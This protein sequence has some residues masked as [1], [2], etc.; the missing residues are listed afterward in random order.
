M[1]DE[2][3]SYQ[4]T[5]RRHSSTAGQEPEPEEQPSPAVAATEVPAR[6]DSEGVPPADFITFVLSLAAQVGMLLDGAEG[7]R[8]DLKGAQWLISIIE[9]LRDKTEGRRTAAETEALE[10]ILYE[11]RLA[12]VERAKVGGA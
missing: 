12:Y 9:M 7:G 1:S 11:L 8:P 3:K 4:V 2:K 6:E 10:R 5:D